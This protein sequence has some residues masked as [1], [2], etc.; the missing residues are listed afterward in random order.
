MMNAK[1]YW[2]CTVVAAALVVG[3]VVPLDDADPSDE[4]SEADSSGEPSSIQ[5]ATPALTGKYISVSEVLADARPG[6]TTHVNGNLLLDSKMTMSGVDLRVSGSIVAP[7]GAEL[8][9]LDGA[10]LTAQGDIV[11]GRLIGGSGGMSLIATGDIY[12]SGD[13][14]GAVNY[15]TT[16]KVT[17]SGMFVGGQ[18]VVGSTVYGAA[19]GAT[20]TASALYVTGGDFVGRNYL[21][22]AT[23]TPPNTAGARIYANLFI[24]QG[25]FIGRDKIE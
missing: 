11:V 10:K 3:C 16:G 14:I 1:S 9:G 21:V 17:V 22:H 4:P 8:E 15:Q 2:M 13:S 25:S 5:S 19:G 23:V 18:K 6:R 24:T 12:V 7:E 20:V